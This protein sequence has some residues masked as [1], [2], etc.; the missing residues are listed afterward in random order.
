MGSRYESLFFSPVIMQ[1]KTE[2]PTC[3]ARLEV[4]PAEPALSKGQG[5]PCHPPSS[6]WWDVVSCPRMEIRNHPAPPAQLPAAHVAQ[7]SCSLL[8]SPL[9]PC[10]LP[11]FAPPNAV[12]FRAWA[13]P[14]CICVFSEKLCFSKEKQSRTKAWL[15]WQLHTLPA[16]FHLQTN[17]PQANNPIPK[18]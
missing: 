16:K 2:R 18:S 11:H 9:K 6:A 1:E 17:L 14:L 8:P 4:C 10:L 15:I 5:E 12:D 3:S 13:K 7:Q